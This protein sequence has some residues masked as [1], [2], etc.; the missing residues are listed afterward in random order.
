M[1]AD[2]NW[3]ELG[4]GYYKTDCH[5]RYV[6]KNGSWGPGQ[7]HTDEMMPMHI[8]ATALHYGQ[9]VFEGLKAYETRDGRPVLFRAIE[10]AKR[11]TRS[12][13][14]ILMQPVPIDLFMEGVHRAVRA[15][16]RFLPP[17]G[18]GASM[19]VRPLLIGTG[20]QIGVKPADEYVFMVMVMPV[21]PYFKTGFKPVNLIVEEE[22]DR[23]APCGV[24][25]IKVAGN[26]A[27]GMRAS[28]AAKAKGYTEVL[29]VDAKKK[30]YIDESGPANF[31][32][33]T[34]D[35]RYITPESPSILPSITNMSLIQLAK[36]MKLK[37]KRRRIAVEEIF[38]FKEA[39]CCG[40]AAVI[41]PVGSITFRERKVEYCPDGKPGH[42]CVE[43]YERLTGIQRGDIKDPHGW[44]TEIPAV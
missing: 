6:W 42:R 33:I 13:E 26:Y 31:F 44:V 38:E 15:N 19:Y 10:N 43:L 7:L 11:M 22:V 9:A 39:G 37:P 16:M 5:I 32:A 28:F 34:Q 21:G 12:A 30:K 29:Y 18:H 40:T 41:T 35:D 25:D 1:K 17:Y 4:F 23:A 36:D 3:K 20:P 8:A 14:K 27:A 2:I 24:G